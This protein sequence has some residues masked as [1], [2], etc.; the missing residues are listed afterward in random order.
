MSSLGQFAQNTQLVR[1]T[2]S[3]PPCWSEGPENAVKNDLFYGEERKG[4]NPDPSVLLFDFPGGARC[5]FQGVGPPI[6]YSGSGP[7]AP[8]A[9]F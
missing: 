1:I 8:A 5:L 3:P 2:A 4:M 6:I 9:R 7:S